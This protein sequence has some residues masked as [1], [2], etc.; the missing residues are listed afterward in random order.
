MI[1]SR[2]LSVLLIALLV[3]GC[4]STA[5][6]QKVQRDQREMRALL[7]DTQVS[8]ER[9][10]RDVDALRDQQ[11]ETGPGGRSATVTDLQRKMAAL[12]QR[13]RA[14]EG[15]PRPIEI[16]PTPTV[17]GEERPPESQIPQSEAGQI[18]MRAETAALQGGAAPAPY[19]SAMDLYKR[20]QCDQAVTQFRQFIRESPT[21]EYVD[22]AQYW[23]GE[24][25]YGK[26]DYNRAII[27]FNEVILKY[28][29]GDRVPSA[30]LALAMSF[31]DSGDKIDARLILQ[32][33]IGEYPKSE[34]AN[35]GRQKL[36]ALTE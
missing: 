30:L 19:R 10:R 27:E 33:L 2:W 4:A 18:A 16:S 5:D 3:G 7:A 14:L 31:A 26:K 20:G 25:Y 35:V 8:V 36:Q 24:C 11:K 15:S 22:N 23:V 34:E 6:M 28:P 1:A 29:K 12:D 13:M 17:S 9:L 21:S 32:K